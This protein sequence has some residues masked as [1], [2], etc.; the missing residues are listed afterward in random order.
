MNAAKNI[1]P[2]GHTAPS[3]YPEAA[4]AAYRQ[5]S[6]GIHAGKDV[7][8]LVGAKF[9]LTNFQSTIQFKRKFSALMMV[10]PQKP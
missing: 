10:T 6:P 3:L 4:L 2:V 7:N 8:Q 1:L 9:S 5:E